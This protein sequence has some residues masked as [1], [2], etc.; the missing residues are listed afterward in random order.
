MSM[1]KLYN[2]NKKGTL[3][4]AGPRYGSHFLAQ[5]IVD[6]L[7]EHLRQGAVIGS[8]S[9]MGITAQRFFGVIGELDYLNSQPGYQVA[10]VNDQSTKMMMIA[11]PELFDSWHIVRIKH[12]DKVHWFK[13]FWYFLLNNNSQFQHHGTDP[14]L[15]QKDLNQHGQYTITPEQLMTV[16][17]N[18]NQPL[19]NQYIACDEHIEY[20]DLSSL[21]TTVPWQSNQ[22]PDVTIRDMFTNGTEVELMLQNWPK[23]VSSKVR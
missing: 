19:L 10:I 7:P 12:N 6:Q 1:Y 23:E 5:A 9:E 22:Y 13:S 8:H 21:E 20:Q 15:Y 3:I 16:G 4:L 18:L 17:W 2:P 14:E 11:R